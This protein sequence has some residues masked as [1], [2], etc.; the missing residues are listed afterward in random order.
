M[1]EFV[2]LSSEP[3]SS[4]SEVRSS[5]AD[6]LAAGFGRLGDAFLGVRGIF[7]LQLVIGECVPDSWLDLG[8]ALVVDEVRRCN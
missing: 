5:P 1:R 3:L 7:G 2:G 6:A 8:V 4:E